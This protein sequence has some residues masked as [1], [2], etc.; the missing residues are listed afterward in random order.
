[1]EKIKKIDIFEALKYFLEQGNRII[2]LK[3]TQEHAWKIL[4][5]ENNNLL[6]PESF[7][8]NEDLMQPLK[9]GLEN[10]LKQNID[11]NPN[12]FQRLPT[13]DSLWNL[14]LTHKLLT[15]EY[16]YAYSNDSP[17]I[18]YQRPIDISSPNSIQQIFYS[19]IELPAFFK[20]IFN[21]SSFRSNI[22]VI[23]QS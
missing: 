19:T 3:F 6:L 14:T 2:N 13:S 18:I 7:L 21:L 20:A 11:T 12:P 22:T 23:S 17:T 4:F 8:F 9:E 10:I 1:M 15:I 16:R 5:L